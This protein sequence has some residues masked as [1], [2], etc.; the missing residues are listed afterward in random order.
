[1]IP[2]PL[3]FYSE[4]SVTIAI[5]VFFPEILLLLTN[6]ERNKKESHANKNTGMSLQAHPY[7]ITVKSSPPHS[8]P[9]CA[10]GESNLPHFL[11]WRVE[12]LVTN[13]KLYVALGSSD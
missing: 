10:G 4:S 11:K 12:G 1:M 7:A 6:K 3:P 9:T 8:I 13:L 5:I 2:K